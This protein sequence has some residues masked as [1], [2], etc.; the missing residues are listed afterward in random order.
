MLA[1][2]HNIQNKLHKGERRHIRGRKSTRYSGVEDLSQL[3]DT[4]PDTLPLPL[5][6]STTHCAY[7]TDDP[8]QLCLLFYTSLRRTLSSPKTLFLLWEHSWSLLVGS[9]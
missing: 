3:T 4:T 1:D 5:L 9:R 2:H 8:L 6:C 7:W